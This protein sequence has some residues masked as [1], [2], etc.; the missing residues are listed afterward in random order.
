MVWDKLP[1]YFY[2]RNKVFTACG[3][4]HLTFSIALKSAR[5]KYP[6]EQNQNQLTARDTPLADLYELR[7]IKLAQG[8]GIHILTIGRAERHCRPKQDSDQISL[9]A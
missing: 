2:K 1:V 4:C 5:L 9:A 3:Q 6:C 7:K 8:A